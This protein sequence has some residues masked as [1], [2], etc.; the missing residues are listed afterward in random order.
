VQ[1]GCQNI[2]NLCTNTTEKINYIVRT[3]NCMVTVANRGFELERQLE[4][5]E[6]EQG[7]PCL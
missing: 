1:A 7:F 6:K 2:P 4:Q 5:P 3:H